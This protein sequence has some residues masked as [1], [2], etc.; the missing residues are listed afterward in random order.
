MAPT[1]R[2]AMGVP[3]SSN[4]LEVA[5]RY[6]IPDDVIEDARQM[7]PEHTR[8]FDTLVAKLEGAT[9]AV[10]REHAA[11]EQERAKLDQSRAKLEARGEA[12][13]MR[14]AKGLGTEAQRLV[15]RSRQLQKQLEQA[16]KALKTG[17]KAN[18]IGAANE[19]LRAGG[20]LLGEIDTHRLKIEP[21]PVETTSL[22]QDSIEPG[23]RVWVER[24]RSVAEV[25]E[26]PA[27]GKVRVSAG[28]MK[29]WVDVSD[30]RA[31]KDA[32]VPARRETKV[33]R[34]GHQ[35]RR[36]IRTA[37]NTL[38][39]RGLRAEEAV[40]LTESFLDRMYGNAEPAAYIVHGIGSGA[41]RDALHEHLAR[42][43][44][45]VEGFR[46]ASQDEGGPQVTVVSLK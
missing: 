7:L 34:A 33:T 14:E 44:R 26:G 31:L 40:A 16:K 13:K 3:G 2:M 43:D 11:L 4:A 45:Y 1:F 18:A 5:R 19:A 41:L 24:L 21:T 38:D 6:G 17:A 10:D 32:P 42:N 22:G 37:D 27:R 15:E 25:I 8:T 30:L 12:L 35:A 28:M 20:R 39:V 9:R 46:A 29:L 36:G 23:D